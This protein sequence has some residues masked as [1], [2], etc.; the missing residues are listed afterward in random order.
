MKNYDF[1]NLKQ[2]ESKLRKH[3]DDKSK[4][5]LKIQSLHVEINNLN[6]SFPNQIKFI[7]RS[8]NKISPVLYSI[9]LE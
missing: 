4:T 2:N 1:E 6:E 8:L 7:E 9:K 5:E 3:Q